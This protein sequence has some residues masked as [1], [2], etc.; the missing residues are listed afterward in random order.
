[1]ILADSSSKS[2]RSLESVFTNQLA[3]QCSWHGQRGNFELNNLSF[4]KL[5]TDIVACQCRKIPSPLVTP[6]FFCSEW[7]RLAKQRLMR[8]QKHLRNDNDNSI[9]LT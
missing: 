4:M 6:K 1:M 3:T 9:Q 7:F 2:S 5:I 8:E